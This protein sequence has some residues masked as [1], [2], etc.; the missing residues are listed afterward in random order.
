MKKARVSRRWSCVISHDV[1][2]RKAHADGSI[3][4]A[5]WSASPPEAR[6]WAVVTGYE[7]HYSSQFDEGHALSAW[8]RT[9]LSGDQALIRGRDGRVTGTILRTTAAALQGTLSSLRSH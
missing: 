4:Q 7:G 1:D 3:P 6:V 5:S 8:R 9:E 2:R